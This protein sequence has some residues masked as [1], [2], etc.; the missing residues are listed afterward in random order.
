MKIIYDDVLTRLE[1]YNIL[2]LIYK[3]YNTHD[4]A[5]CIYYEW[6]WVPK[7]TEYHVFNSFM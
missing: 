7:Q 6:N 2:L 4:A 1:Y 5:L 3:F